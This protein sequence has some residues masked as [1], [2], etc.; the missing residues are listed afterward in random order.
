MK[1]DMTMHHHT[2]FRITLTNVE[3]HALYLSGAP[4]G[5]FEILVP[6]QRSYDTCIESFLG[7]HPLGFTSPDIKARV[8]PKDHAVKVV[9][10]AKEQFQ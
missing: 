6:W 5:H 10:W 3:T 1:M 8:K 7:I 2:F 9:H 4:F